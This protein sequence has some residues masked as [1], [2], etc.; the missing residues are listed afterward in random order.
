MASPLVSGNF[1]S[2]LDPRYRDVAMGTYEQGKS[3]IPEIFTVETSDMATE[4]YS[5]LTP[6]GKFQTFTGAVSYDGADEGYQVTATHLEKALGVQIQ[7]KLYDDAQFNVI[8]EQFANLGESAFKTHEDDAAELLVGAFSA[9]NAF[10]SHTEAVALCSNSHTCPRSGVATTTGFDNLGTSALSPTALTAAIIQMRQ[11][12]DDSG[13]VIDIQPDEIWVPV[14]LAD[15]VTEIL[16]TTQGLDDA[17]ENV[18]VHYNRLTPKVWHRLSDANDWFITDSA[19]RK[20]NAIFFWRVKL[21]LAK[22]ESFDNIVAKG[23]GYL[24]YSFLRRDWRFIQGNQVS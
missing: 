20:K 11:F 5:Q 2:V 23:R 13:A 1:A 4:R 17:N 21:E 6:M 15:R 12:K 22:M 24:R 18:N 9:T 16:K 19:L 8:E 7:R 10:Y 3:W 14:N